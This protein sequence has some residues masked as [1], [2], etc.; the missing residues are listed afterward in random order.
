MKKGDF[1][2]VKGD[3]YVYQII[4]IDIERNKAK[5]ENGHKQHFIVEIHLL[6]KYS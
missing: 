3:S 1:V 4:D 2:I 5:I 6:K